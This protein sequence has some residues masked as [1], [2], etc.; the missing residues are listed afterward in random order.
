V[1]TDGLKELE[2]A[3]RKAK[4]IA[5]ER[6]AKLQDLVEDR[7]LVAYAEPPEAARAAYEACREWVVAEAS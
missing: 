2:I 7:L 5:A 3:V 6:A 1:S 4:R